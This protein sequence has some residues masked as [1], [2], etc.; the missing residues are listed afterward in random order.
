M[1]SEEGKGHSD[2]NTSCHFV[3]EVQ[4]DLRRV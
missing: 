3:S 4:M 1:S 2:T